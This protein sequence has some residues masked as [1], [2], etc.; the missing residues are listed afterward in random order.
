MTASGTKVNSSLDP[1]DLAHMVDVLVA[2]K[3]RDNLTQLMRVMDEDLRSTFDALKL[4]LSSSLPR[5]VRAVVQQIN[6]EAQ[7]KRM[8]GLPA[9]L[10][11]NPTANPSSSDTMINVNQPSGSGNPNLQQP[12]YHTVSYGPSIPPM[13]NGVKHGPVPDVMFP[14]ATGNILNQVG[15]SKVGEGAMTDGVRE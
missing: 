7:G 4:D 9:I 12:F 13:G 6:N 3:Y 10:N 1:E 14:R 5:Q 15:T 2:S 8:E 11:P